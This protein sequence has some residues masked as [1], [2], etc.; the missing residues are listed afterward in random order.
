MGVPFNADEIF[1]MAEEIEI[2]GAMFYREAAKKYPAVKD[3]LLELASM[4]DEHLKTFAAMRKEL[5]EAEAETS[6]FD[7]DNQIQMYL[8]VMADEHVF[9]VKIAPDELLSRQKSPQD[10]LRMA[11]R[12]EK[13]S[14]AFYTGLKESVSRQTGRDK[15]QEIIREELGH[16]VTISHKLRDI[17]N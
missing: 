3:V 4:E 9:N 12:L 17:T 2:N 1:E 5:S 15:V 6:V 10:V 7:P 14:I 8:K 13:D 11:I 16:I